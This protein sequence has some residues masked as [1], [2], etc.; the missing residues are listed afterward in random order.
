MEMNLGYAPTQTNTVR[1]W[2]GYVCFL[3]FGIMIPFSR[4]DAKILTF[5]ASLAVS[6]IMGF[7]AVMILITVI[8]AGN[9]ELRR[10]TN[11]QL[12]RE[13][14]SSGMV[15]MIPFTVLAVVALLL[16]NWNAVMPFA[17]AAVTTAAASAGTEVMK[18]GAPG[19]KN[20]IIPSLIALLVSTGW[21]MLVAILP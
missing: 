16:L 9:P 17:S 4:S 14:V 8:N 12:G 11:G 3:M 7:L 1:L 20:V 18:K 13:A 15:Y 10:Q 6:F 19:A 2:P 21:M 5:V